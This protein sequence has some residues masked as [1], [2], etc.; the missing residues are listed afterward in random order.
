MKKNITPIIFSAL[1][2]CLTL[3]YMVYAW[4]EPTESMPSSE[5]D[6]PINTG[7]EPQSKEGALGIGIDEPCENTKLHVYGGNIRVDNGEYQSW[8]ELVL[9]PDV[10]NSGDGIVRV[11]N[12]NGQVFRIEDSGDVQVSGDLTFTTDGEGNSIYKISNIALPIDSTD[13]ATKEYVDA[14]GGEQYS[15]CYFI[16]SNSNV[17]CNEGY[18]TVLSSKGNGCQGGTVGLTGF[19]PS[20]FKISSYGCGSGSTKCEG[21]YTLMGEGWTN[22]Y[23]T[24]TCYSGGTSYATTIAICC[25]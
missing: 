8:S 23:N 22:I 13:V 15:E 18:T 21:L 2:F 6:P 12:R 11:E 5:V 9:R 24:S 14:A 19:E 17:D 3:S 10:D 20:W 25:K 1:I 4:N 16:V 7:S